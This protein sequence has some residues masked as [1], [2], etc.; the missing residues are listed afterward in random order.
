M[1]NERGKVLPLVPYIKFRDYTSISMYLMLV[2]KEDS[3]QSWNLC[4][5]VVPKLIDYCIQ[6]EAWPKTL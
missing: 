5:S 4:D 2:D 3:A 6:E 1:N